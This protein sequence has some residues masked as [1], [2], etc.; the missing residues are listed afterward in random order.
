MAGSVGRQVEAVRYYWT[1][2]KGMFGETNDV[3]L[4]LV[5]IFSRHEDFKLQDL[6]VGSNAMY[7]LVS[8]R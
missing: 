2:G 6:K 5:C 3:E 7:P 4:I 8:W 1:T